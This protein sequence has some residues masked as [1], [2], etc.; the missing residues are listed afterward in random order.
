MRDH[1]WGQRK[2]VPAW[3][4][5]RGGQPDRLLGGGADAIL[6]TEFWGFETGPVD[7]TGT[8]TFTLEEI[9]GNGT[10][11]VVNP[12]TG[13]ATWTLRNAE[14]TADGV[15]ITVG[16]GTLVL[17]G[18]SL[19][20]SGGQ[21]F[22]GNAD[23]GLHNVAVV[24]SGEQAFVGSSGLTAEAV[25]FDADGVYTPA[26]TGDSAL[27]IQNVG[28][29]G[30]GYWELLLYGTGNWSL[31]SVQLSAT[32]DYKNERTG[33]ASWTSRPAGVLGSGHVERFSR[34][35]VKE[36]ML[37]WGS[38]Y[39]DNLIETRRILIT[40]DGGF[41]VK[42]AN[43]TGSLILHGTALAASPDHDSAVVPQASEFDCIGAAYGDIPSGGEGWVVTSGMAEFLLK[44]GTSATRGFWAKA[45]DTDGRIVVTT[46]P[47][48]LS[49]LSTSEHF[50][51]VGH[52]LESVTAG[53]NKLALI[54]LHFL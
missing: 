40:P 54:L 42:L 13:T 50:R 5:Q 44:D 45:A 20:G 32:G 38:L 6:A 41:A 31:K 27:L 16:V 23:I 33:S 51:E 36:R 14:I 18:L 9:R 39:V 17:E 43:S 2:R 48:S 26:I 15:Y 11:V 28:V 47:A 53:T 4:G 12:L 22:A 19:A 24:G 52:C 25:Q 37:V 21:T 10:G 3:Q 34:Y 29:V 49:A 35:W 30:T 8:G 46:P 7:I 1:I